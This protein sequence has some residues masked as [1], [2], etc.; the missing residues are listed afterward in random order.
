MKTVTIYKSLVQSH[1]QCPRRAWLEASGVVEPKFSMSALA[2]MRQGGEVGAAART[3]FPGHTL[4]SGGLPLADAAAVTDKLMADGANDIAEAAFVAGD[5]GVRMDMLSR[6]GDGWKMTEV[7]SGGKAIDDEYLNDV[8]IQRHCASLAGLELKSVWVMHPDTTKVRTAGG[9]GAEV[10]VAEDVT[11]YATARAGMAAQWIE[12]CRQTLAGCD[13]GTTPG[14]QCEKPNTCPF[15]HYC[16][17]PPVNL[18]TDLVDFLPAKSPRPLKK[19]LESG[20]RRITGI[21]AESL[22]HKRNV[23]VHAAVCSGRNVVVSE[24]AEFMARLP[25]KRYI[26]DFEAASFAIPR[27]VGTRPHQAIPFQWSCHR[28]DT[29]WT[30]LRHSEF[31]DVTGNDPRRGFIESLLEEVGDSGPI[32]VYSSYERSRLRELAEAFPDLQQPID[33]MILRLVDLLP[34]A[35]RGYYSPTMRG[36]W[37]IKRILPTLPRAAGVGLYDDLADIAEGTAAQAAY[38][39]Q[40]DPAVVGPQKERRRQEMLDYC[41]TDTAALN[42][43]GEYVQGC[44]DPEKVVPQREMVVDIPGALK[45]LAEA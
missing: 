38:M 23:L 25:F 7:K 17:K 9:S 31:L 28:R 22:V 3:A 21:P 27:F 1:R 35:R 39:E 6:E 11:E 8:A 20:V 2:M 44:F 12:E 26:V 18:D 33:A 15:S 41:K 42:H 30:P 5:L 4:V 29:P 43:F 45:D 24:F 14:E 34:L 40:I 10:L 13:P 32:M 36:S 16:G 19:V 37:S